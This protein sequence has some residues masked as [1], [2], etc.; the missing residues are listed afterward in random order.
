[1]TTI[2]ATGKSLNH[3]DGYL[4]KYGMKHKIVVHNRSSKTI[5][6]IVKSKMYDAINN[7][8]IGPQLGLCISTVRHPED[9]PEQKIVL[10]PYSKCKVRLTNNTAFVSLI[11]DG[12][13]LLENRQMSC[14]HD[15]IVDEAYLWTHLTNYCPNKNTI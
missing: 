1:M 6:I 4:R 14:S 13:T 3:G 2:I 7:V 11:V 12:C 5:T 15:L 8:R 9:F 10:Q